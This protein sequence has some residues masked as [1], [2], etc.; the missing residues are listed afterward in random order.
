[1]AESR[2]GGPCRRCQ[3]RRTPLDGLRAALRFEGTARAAIHALKYRGATALAPLLSEPMAAAL[4]AHPLLVDLV[5]PVPLHPQRERERGYNQSALLASR[6]AAAAGLPPPTPLLRRER[7]T[8]SQV[9]LSARERRDN[10]RGAFCCVDPRAA[11]GRRGLLVDDVV[12][13]GA[14]L[15]ACAAT[16]RAAGVGRVWGL[17][18]AHDDGLARAGSTIPPSGLG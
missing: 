14:T 12:T 17:A 2:T 5:V 10:V 8:R 13:T 9:G 6:L 16:L 1:V 18:L 11:A 3:S 7:D 4:A 15:E